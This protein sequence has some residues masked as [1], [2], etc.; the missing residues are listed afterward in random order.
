MVLQHITKGHEVGIVVGGVCRVGRGVDEAVVTGD[1]VLEARGAVDR[2][3][4]DQ[5]DVCVDDIGI[6]EFVL[7]AAVVVFD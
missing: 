7:L 5:V 1:R 6:A 4:G 2:L 3:V